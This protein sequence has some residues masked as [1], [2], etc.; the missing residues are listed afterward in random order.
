MISKIVCKKILEYI[1]CFL[2]IGIKEFFKKKTRKKKSLMENIAE[3]KKSFEQ[4]L[5]PSLFTLIIFLLK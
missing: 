4:Y 2:N 3:E 5:N 1:Y